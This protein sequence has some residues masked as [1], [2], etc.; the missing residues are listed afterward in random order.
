MVVAPS[1]IRLARPDVRVHVRRKVVQI[2]V[3]Q[4]ALRAI[5]TVAT[6]QG[7]GRPPNPLIY[8]HC[9]GSSI[10]SR[11]RFYHEN[12]VLCG[13]RLPFPK[14]WKGLSHQRLSEGKPSEPPFAEG[15]S[16]PFLPFPLLTQRQAVY[17]KGSPRGPCARPSQGC[18]NT[19]TTDRTSCHRHGCH[20]TGQH[21]P[22]RY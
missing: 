1:L 16:P 17:K 13:F 6:E 3:R 21:R 18:S 10:K 7:K 22:V 2:P 9:Q 12:T 4:T 15:K 11:C 5:A 14:S 8:P 20:R 19:S